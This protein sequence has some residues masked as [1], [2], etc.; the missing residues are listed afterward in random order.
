[1]ED[2][3]G[4]RIRVAAVVAGIVELRG[5]GLCGEVVLVEGGLVER[6]DGVEGQVT[7]TVGCGFE[8]VFAFAFALDWLGVGFRGFE[9][10]GVG[11]DT[12]GSG[13]FGM[14]CGLRVGIGVRVRVGL[15]TVRSSL[16]PKKL[17][18]FGTLVVA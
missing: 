13:A 5:R 11:R 16:R 18:F 10:G 8:V 1:M 2:W 3:Y 14:T 15:G 9:G 12:A 4:E 17:T 6:V 7:V